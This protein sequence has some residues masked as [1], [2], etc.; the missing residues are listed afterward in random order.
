[1]RSLKYLLFILFSTYQINSFGQGASCATAVSLTVDGVCPTGSITDGTVA[2]AA[3]PT[4]AGST[5]VSRD[6]W[7]SYTVTSGP[8]NISIAVSNSN[9]DIIVQ[10]FSGTCTGTLTQIGCSNATTGAGASTETVNISNQSNGTYFVRVVATNSATISSICITSSANNECAG[11]IT[12]TPGATCSTTSGTLLNATQSQTGCSGT[13]DDDVWYKFVATATSHTFTVDPG[14]SA[15]LVVEMFSGSCGSL[16]SLVCDDDAFTD[17]TET[18]TVGGLTIGNTYFIRVYTWSS[19]VTSTPAFTICITN[20]PPGPANDE[21][22]TAA[23]L[24]P[25]ATCSGTAGTVANSTNSGITGCLG[26]ANDDVWYKFT[27]A[28]ST[29]YITLTSTMDA[30]MEVFGGTCGALSSVACSD[31]N[32]MTVTGLT[33][34][35]VYYLRIFSWS[36]SAPADGSFSVCITNPPS[37]PSG[38]GSGVV[39]I[40]SL[41]YS[42]G[43]GTTC[44]AGDEITSSNA[45]VCGSTSYYTGEDKV[46]SFTPTSSGQITITLTSSGTWTGLMLYEGCPFSGTCTAYS[47][48]ST[49]NKSLTACVTSGVTYYLVLDSY[50]APACNAYSNLTISSVTPPGSCNLGT[51]VVNVASLPYSSGAGTTAGAVDDLTSSNMLTCGSSSY[52]TGEDRVFVFTPA[53]SGEVT[54]NLTS[55]GTWTGL[56]LYKGCPLTTTC[57]GGSPTCVA[58]DQSSTGNKSLCASL[59]GGVTY[60]LVLDSYASPANNPYTNLTI[61]A[62]A[63]SSGGN[64]CADAINIA[65]LPFSQTGRTTACKPNTYTSSHACQSSYMNG[66]DYVYKYTPATNQCVKITLSNTATYTGVFVTEGCPDVACPNCTGFNTNSAGNPTISSLSLTAGI[67]YY[68]IVSTFPSPQSTPF[69]ISITTTSCSSTTLNND[70]CENPQL[71]TPGGSGITTNTNTYTDDTPGNIS[72][73]FCGSIENNQWFSFVATS[74]SMSFN[75]SIVSGCTSGIQAEVYRVVP[76][77][78]GTC[79]TFTSVSNCWNPATQTNGTVTATGLT[80]GNTYYLM[81]DGY[82]GALCNFTISNWGMSAL[83]IE[84]LSFDGFADRTS[85]TLNWVTVSESGNDFFTIERSSTG[86]NFVEIGRVDGNGTSNS[87]HEYTFIDDSPFYPITYYRLKQTDFDGSVTYSNIIAIQNNS[88]KAFK[89]VDAYPNPFEN[90]IKAKIYTANDMEAELKIYDTQGRELISLKQ[91]LTAGM[92]TIGISTEILSGGAYYMICKS[93]TDNKAEFKKIFKTK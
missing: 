66:N 24:T 72:S 90:E 69:D 89:L 50:A 32:S 17:G 21:C 2:D 61:S 34:G 73:E 35:N 80:I 52:L 28:A 31:P 16:S 4:C 63:G 3:A 23:T 15:D 60:Y 84:L 47:Q 29:Q 59:T 49:G 82:G 11:A 7:W 58:Y 54:I 1:M 6:G 91:P 33:A 62:P 83:D 18:E 67:T 14:T 13:A 92:N 38:L 87:R 57:S 88:E 27:A 79:G 53:T 85:N 43:A 51:G 86:E 70:L 42:A 37:C 12:L 65:S 81:V 68:I 41:P 36:S 22:S 75:F 93:M 40:A 56:M 8:T 76:D 77:A 64:T 9:R 39:S 44:G 71:L 5:T 30:V 10:V 19:T 20:P 45:V 26:T 55:S 46:W 25:G 78:C 48:S 74:A